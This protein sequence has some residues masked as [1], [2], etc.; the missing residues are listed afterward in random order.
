[1]HSFN[2]NCQQLVAEAEAVVVS[3]DGVREQEPT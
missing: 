3:A 2:P 1:M